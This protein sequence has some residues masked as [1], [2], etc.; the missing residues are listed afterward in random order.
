MVIDTI[1]FCYF[2]DPGQEARIYFKKEG[3]TE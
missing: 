2:V 1:I 3:T